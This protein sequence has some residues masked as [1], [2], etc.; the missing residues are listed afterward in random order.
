MLNR[1]PH[2]ILNLGHETYCKVD[3]HPRFF[4]NFLIFRQSSWLVASK[5]LSDHQALFIM[6]YVGIYLTILSAPSHA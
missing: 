4:F 3:D 6:G 1:N 2:H 5:N